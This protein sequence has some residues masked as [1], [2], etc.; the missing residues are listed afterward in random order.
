[1]KTLRGFIAILS[2]TFAAAFAVS[3]QSITSLDGASVNVAGQNGKVVV[4][5][6]GASW[7]PLSN[8]QAEF[9]NALAKKYAGRNVVFYFIATDS[10][11]AGSKNFASID[12]IRRFANGNKL[13]VSVLRDTDGAATLRKFSV[14]QVPSFVILDKTG[15]QAGEPIGG[16]DPTGKYDITIPI[17]KAIDRLL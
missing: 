3:A 9:T 14:E 8:K 6:I 2:L 13:T 1:M 12:S 5:A 11:N 15:K 17:S 4:L 10:T 16:I 7:L